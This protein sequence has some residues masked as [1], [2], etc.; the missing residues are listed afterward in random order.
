LFSVLVSVSV[1]QN[2]TVLLVSLMQPHSL[3]QVSQ[4]Y[5]DDQWWISE[6]TMDPTSV[7]R[8]DPSFSSLL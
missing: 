5:M 2:I 1:N 8:H 4:H 6:V 7:V 3:S